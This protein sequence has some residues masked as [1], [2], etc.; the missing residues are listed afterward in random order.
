MNELLLEFA[1]TAEDRE[2]VRINPVRFAE[3]HGLTKGEAVDL[4][5]HARKDGLVTMEWQYVCPGC[6]EVVER[7]TSL[8]SASS[9]FFCQICSSERD[10]DLSDFVEITFTSIA[11]IRRSRYHDPWSLEPEEHFFGYRFTQSGVIEDGTPLREHLRAVRRRLRLRRAGRDADVLSDGGAGYLWFTSGPALVVGEAAPMRCRRFAF[12]YT[13]TRSEG[14]RAKIAAGP[15]EMD[16]TNATDERYALMIIDLAERLQ[17]RMEPFLSGAELLSNQTFLDLFAT[18]TIVA[19]EGL[20]VRRL[21]LLFT[22]VR[23]R[24]RSTSGSAT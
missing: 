1:R 15:V 19:G 21:A 3:Q 10:T 23:A 16:F 8:T 11:E 20:A 18:E 5:L 14:F 13:G 4:F 17:V 6:G 7:L 24:P 2:L 9:H 12:E 22:D